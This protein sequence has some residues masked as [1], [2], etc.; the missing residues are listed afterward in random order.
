MPFQVEPMTKCSRCNEYAETLHHY[1]VRFKVANRY[2][3]DEYRPV[4]AP[5][6]TLL[7]ETAGET[8][9]AEI[10][11]FCIQSILAKLVTTPNAISIE[12]VVTLVDG[13]QMGAQPLTPTGTQALSQI[14]A[15]IQATLDRKYPA[16]LATTKR[17]AW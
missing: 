11:S 13:Y 17:P 9:W 1:A 8:A 10:N 4:C 14:V 7:R 2:L 3:I 16:P 15:I 6:R 5:C 12:D